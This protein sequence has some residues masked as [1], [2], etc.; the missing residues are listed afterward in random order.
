VV[1]QNRDNKAREPVV[2]ARVQ[3]LVEQ[4]ISKTKYKK[5]AKE[6]AKT[7]ELLEKLKTKHSNTQKKYKE[8]CETN[9]DL[10]EKVRRY[11][12]VEA[13]LVQLNKKFTR[14]K[15]DYMNK[16][17]TAK[18]DMENCTK[19]KD[20]VLERL[21]RY[22]KKVSQ[23]PGVEKFEKKIQK[24][25]KKI[26]EN[27]EMY[28]KSEN[29]KEKYKALVKKYI[30][31]INEKIKENN[32]LKKTIKKLR[33]ENKELKKTQSEP[34]DSDRES[35][36]ED[37]EPPTSKYTTKFLQLK[38]KRELHDLCRSKGI[39]GYSKKNKGPLIIFMLAHPKMK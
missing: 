30:G 33:D 23:F 16:Y 1:Q 36:C 7:Q 3:E 34:E 10:V 20:R 19:E 37:E 22:K 32:R 8:G 29:D 27:D 17:R 21:E 15:T 14:R 4:R 28:K 39:G 13:K 12:T 38:T 9:R 18:T 2:K 11:S 25:E 35:E 6:L 26:K 5:L 24:Y 31:M